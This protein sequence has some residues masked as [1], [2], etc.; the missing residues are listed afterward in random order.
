MA[1]AALLGGA[2][3]WWSRPR[4][5][6]ELYEARCA[7]CHALPDLSHFGRDDMARIVATMRSR[8]G[9]DAVIDEEEARIIVRYLEQERAP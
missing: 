9:A 6:Q 7:S 4:T 5:P 2:V 3:W 8:N 1:L